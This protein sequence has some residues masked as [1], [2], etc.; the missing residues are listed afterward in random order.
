MRPL[1]VVLLWRHRR[2]CRSSFLFLFDGNLRD[3]T[4]HPP[5]A[6]TLDLAESCVLGEVVTDTTL[7]PRCGNT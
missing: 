2:R 7:P 1:L 3:Q 5:L 6:I 4:P